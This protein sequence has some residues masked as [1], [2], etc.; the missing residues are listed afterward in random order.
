M[1]NGY[2][3]FAKSAI[4]YGELMTDT[5]V[6]GGG[7]G[8]L[9]AAIRLQAQ[10]FQVRLLEKRDRVGGR[11]YVYHDKGFTFDAGPTV[12]TAPPCI[13]ELFTL[14]GRRMED[15]VELLPVTP[16]YR[17]YWE[18][19]YRFDY[20]NDL[21]Q[22]REQI[23][24]KSPEDVQGYEEFLKYT[25]K[26]FDEGYTKLAHVPFLNWGS[27][28]QVSPQLLKLQAYRSVYSMV[29]KFI[30]D[31][32]LRQAFS[33]HSLLVGG[34]P[35]ATSSIYTLIH[36]L[37]RQWGVYFP[38][39]GTG[40]LVA[41]L[42]KLFTDLGG[43]IETDCEIEKI[44]VQ[45][46]KVAGVQTKAGV[47]HSAQR[48]VSNADVHETYTRLLSGEPQVK[49][50]Q[51]KVRG[52]RY[53]MSL[54]VLYFGTSRRF[55]EIAHHNI[56]FG[57]R[58]KELLRDIFKT[59]KLADDFSLY[60]HAPSHT[61][62]S[63]A[64]EG[65]EAFYVLSPV[66]HLGNADLDWNEIGPKY[67]DRILDY[68]DSRYLPGLRESLVTQRI[69]TPLDF[70]QELGAHLGS[71][72]SLEPILRQSAYFRIHNRDA[73]LP[74]LYFVGA[75][76]HPG[77]GIPGVINSAKATAALMVQDRQQSTVV[78]AQP[79]VQDISGALV[80]CRDMI[81]KG[82][83]SFS[84]ASRLFS[85]QTRD[86]AHLLYGWCRYCDDQIDETTNLRL[87]EERAVQLRTQTQAAFAGEVSTNPVFIAFGHLVRRYGIPPHYAMELI[88]GMQM[89]VRKERYWTV[90]ELSLYA[91]RVAGTVGLMMSHIMGVSDAAALKNAA[92]LGTA[93]QLTNIARDV[94]EDARRRRVYLPL[95]WLDDAGIP[96][97]QVDAPRY[98][99]K[100]AE[101][102]ARL[103]DEA[104][105]YYASGKAGL[106]FLPLRCALAVAVAARVYSEIGNRVRARGLHAWD[107]RTV[108]PGWKKLLLVAAGAADVVATLPYRMGHPFRAAP[109]QKVLEHG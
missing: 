40:A 39:G 53:S 67:A 18:D 68:L 11:A 83:L 42:A 58:Y 91:Y 16:L 86:A 65:G 44:V 100:L 105:R 28:V 43:V 45:D 99:A 54:F 90:D 97:T 37:E 47:F 41:G 35:F 76:T 14:A 92:D 50:A 101:V 64:P 59:G 19:G 6:I 52:A 89:D 49:S 82:S 78:A 17:L 66:P 69:F 107:T 55:P 70:K 80:Q 81:R 23:R 30:K 85:A 79:K 8:G 109:L 73:H 31:P 15:Y 21:D 20:T 32:Q 46:Q 95:N 74:G 9:A 22:T 7:F 2:F 94:V 61:D 1:L 87:Q 88:E 71:A 104:D 27:M 36:F 102:T 108:V 57:P 3:G 25:E 26:V 10:G 12:I 60:L 13:E 103:L 4:G 62:R 106:K 84:L 24:R 93:M 33:F 48:V 5:I 29:S 38:K 77:A 63:M 51:R 96:E 75:G 34:N 72:F 56:L 98:R